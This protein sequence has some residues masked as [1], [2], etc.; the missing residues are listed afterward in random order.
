MSKSLLKPEII[1]VE[2]GTPEWFQARMGIP[3][4]SMFGTV[5]ARGKQGGESVGRRKY[6]LQLAGERLTKQPMENYSNDHM[7]RGKEQ[8][9]VALEQYEFD[10]DHK[11]QRVGFV[12]LGRAGCSPDGFVGKDGMV[13]FKSVLPHILIDIHM[14]GRVPPEHLPQCYGGM[15]IADRQWL[16]FVAYSPGLPSYVQRLVR[17]GTETYIDEIAGAVGVFNRELDDVVKFMEKVT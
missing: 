5:M 11:V 6:M 15:W 10:T 13:E 7:E 2:Q 12:R 14:R 16:D 9:P 3:T 17:G 4:A 1:D 8:E